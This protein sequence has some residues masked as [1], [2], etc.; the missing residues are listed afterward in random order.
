[1]KNKICISLFI[2]S[3]ALASQAQKASPA[4]IKN[5][6]LMGSHFQNGFALTQ[7]KTAKGKVYFLVNIQNS[8]LNKAA[9]ITKKYYQSL[10]ADIQRMDLVLKNKNKNMIQRKLASQ[11]SFSLL[12]K[13]ETPESS[14][15]YCVEK[16]D[17]AS[18]LKIQDWLSEAGQL[19]G[20]K[21]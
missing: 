17:R 16:L 5:T 12:F 10:L 11:C 15:T 2:I 21:N 19:T 13:G 1:M 8:N 9:V 7:Q 14:D 4:V 3:F 20:V 6:I 18:Q